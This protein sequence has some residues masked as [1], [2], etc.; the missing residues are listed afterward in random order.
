MH[1][2]PCVPQEHN[3]SSPV[4]LNAKHRITEALQPSDGKPALNNKCKRLLS[5]VLFFLTKFTEKGGKALVF[6]AI[7]KQKGRA[8]FLKR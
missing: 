8:S 1:I 7:G 2:H 4:L 5:A 3:A 6:S